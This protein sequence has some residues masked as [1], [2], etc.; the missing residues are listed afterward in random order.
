MR[1]LCHDFAAVV[2]LWLAEWDPDESM[3]MPHTSRPQRDW[4]WERHESIATSWHFQV[5]RIAA[6]IGRQPMVLI[7][8]HAGVWL[9]KHNM[10]DSEDRYA[11]R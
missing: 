1:P 3:L 4:P 8:M 9:H 6:N 7:E 10:I 2:A 5:G 11:Q